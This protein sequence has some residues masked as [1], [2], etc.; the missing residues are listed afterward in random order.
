[1]A[2][3]KWTPGPWKADIRRGCVVIYP[4]NE[5]HESLGRAEEWAIHCKVGRLVRDDQGRPLRWEV[6]EE[7]V[8]NARLIAAAPDLYDALVALSAAVECCL[9]EPD[10]VKHAVEEAKVALR[11]ARGEE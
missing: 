4:A 2:E 3:P 1:M 9:D 11:K 8:A 10:V 6:P 7:V 5:H